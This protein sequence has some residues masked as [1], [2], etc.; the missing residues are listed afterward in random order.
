MHLDTY[1]FCLI[2][3]ST[4]NQLNSLSESAKRTLISQCEVTKYTIP[5]TYRHMYP[6][7]WCFFFA[8]HSHSSTME[9]NRNYCSSGVMQWAL[10]GVPVVLFVGPVCLTLATP[11]I[12]PAAPNQ[13]PTAASSPYCA[14]SHCFK[15]QRH[16]TFHSRLARRNVNQ[17][18]QILCN[19]PIYR[20]TDA[21]Y[22]HFIH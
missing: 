19:L 10:F 12:P 18:V 22:Y 15:S 3:R 14:V 8:W 4:R 11:P 20:L 6:A 21:G 17:W 7:L 9:S 2:T 16:V 5:Y 1:Y 13:P